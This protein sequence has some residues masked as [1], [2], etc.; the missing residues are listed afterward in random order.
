MS[1][2]TPRSGVANPGIWIALAITLC[3]CGCS[4]FSP[5]R[6][7]TSSANASPPSGAIAGYIWDSRVQGLRPL[8]GSLGAAHLESPLTGPALHSATPCP[9]HGFA[10]GSD[11]SGSVFS[12]SLPS[13]Q[14]TKLGGRVATDQQLTLSPS[15]ANGLVYSPSHGSGLLISGLPSS[16]GVQ[17]IALRTSG[18]LVS[19]AIS[20]S[21]AILVSA[22]KSDGTATLEILSATGAAQVLSSPVQ[23]IGGMAFLP[24]ADSAII[25]DSAANT[26]YLGKQFSSGPSFAAIAASAQGVSNPRAVATS[27]D[28]HFAFVANGAGNNLLRIDLTS[29]AAPLAIACG[30]SPTEFIPL[31]GNAGFQITDA[32]AGVIF[33]LNGDGLTPR[34]VFVPTD[35]AGAAAGGAQ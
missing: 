20:D 18:P 2:R 10:L 1:V 25:A 16:P 28:G 32:A 15:C 8:S 11:A 6:S 7:G 19:A 21:G 29:A 27:S 4:G 9:A 24:G 22:P 26:V 34:T 13:G 31:A 33:A 35:K 5:S 3:F 30:C 12:I 17:S 14:P 23:K